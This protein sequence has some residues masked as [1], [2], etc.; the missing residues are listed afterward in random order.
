LT[1]SAA[2]DACRSAKCWSAEFFLRR[3]RE[4]ADGEGRTFAGTNL[5]ENRRKTAEFQ[6]HPPPVEGLSV[7]GAS[8]P[9]S[10]FAAGIAVDGTIA[11]Y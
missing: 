6:R 7:L 4:G 11:A 8:A 3:Q 1:D 2:N 9:W 10:E 5:R